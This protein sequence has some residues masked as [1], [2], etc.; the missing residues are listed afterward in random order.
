M[1]E[2]S[3]AVTKG[4]ALAFA[5]LLFGLLV[6]AGVAVASMSPK[7]GS[8]SGAEAL[9]SPTPAGCSRFWDL[10]DTH[11]PST[12]ESILYGGDAL[13]A[14]DIW[15]VGFDVYSGLIEHWDG[16]DWSILS[17]SQVLTRTILNDVVAIA[18]N[19]VWAVGHYDGDGPY[20]SYITHWDG[21]TWSEVPNPGA[22]DDSGLFGIDALS[23]N[24]IWAVGARWFT[25]NTVIVLRW[26]G[27][28]WSNVPTPV[29]LNSGSLLFAVD[30]LAPDDVWAVG[31]QNYNQTL[32]MHWDGTAW[33]IMPTV[34]NATLYGV[35]A[36]DE[37]D[38]WAVGHGDTSGTGLILHWDG[39]SWN[40]SVSDSGSY[41]DV[42]AFAPDNVLVAAE[43]T[44]IKQW[45][46]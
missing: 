44:Y 37:N 15:A 5:A 40:V 12:E 26:D 36:L 1:V 7:V 35:S 22:V 30:A 46:G 8:P 32:L 33:T 10:T 20:K 2:T 17:D 16:T 29:L 18:P 28:S 41:R 21:S 6:F 25:D 38:A 42:K 14:N 39:T 45:D 4:K 13:A 27:T 3:W 9:A 31:A 19:D 24:D 34:L 23:A 11:I 43:D